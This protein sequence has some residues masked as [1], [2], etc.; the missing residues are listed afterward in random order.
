MGSRGLSAGSKVR[1][2]LIDHGPDAQPGRGARVELPAT[3]IGPQSS[4]RIRD[5]RVVDLHTPPRS[6]KIRLLQ[7]GQDPSINRS[8]TLTTSHCPPLALPIPT[9]RHFAGCLPRITQVHVPYLAPSDRETVARPV[10][11]TRPIQLATRATDN[12]Q[13]ALPA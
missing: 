5:S 13:H 6:A 3:G 8:T 4:R 1:P 2:V 11:I 7:K 10:A 12:R 9:L